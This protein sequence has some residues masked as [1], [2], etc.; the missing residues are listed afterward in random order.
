MPSITAGASPTH[1]H[2]GWW[3]P[4]GAASHRPHARSLRPNATKATGPNPVPTLTLDTVRDRSGPSSVQ[5]VSIWDRSNPSLKI[6]W[7]G[8]GLDWTVP[9]WTDPLLDWWNHWIEYM[10]RTY[11]HF[12]YLLY[13][14][15]C[16]QLVTDI[17]V[18]SPIGSTFKITCHCRF[19][20]NR[21]HRL[22][23]NIP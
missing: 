14:T 11:Y 18:K 19:Q 3:R 21:S 10:Q 23:N 2:G 16:Q 1:Q 17:F 7:T 20:I 6:S 12:L 13:T 5:S 9:V 15:S 8:P 4:M 22:S